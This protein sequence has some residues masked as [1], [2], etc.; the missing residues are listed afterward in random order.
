MAYVACVT[1]LYAHSAVRV[2]TVY[3]MG[4]V[5]SSYRTDH[6]KQLSLPQARGWCASW[7]LSWRLASCN[8]TETSY[9]PTHVVIVVLY[10]LSVILQDYEG[11][12]RPGLKPLGFGTKRGVIYCQ[13]TTQLT[14]SLTKCVAVFSA[15]VQFC[16]C[17][18][19]WTHLTYTLIIIILQICFKHSFFSSDQTNRHF[20][21]I[22]RFHIVSISYL[23]LHKRS[24][25]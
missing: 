12:R 4:I 9:T 5:I 20:R 19:A 16:S 8:W 10:Y 21:C 15:F 7:L 13:T 25:F 1:S 17:L 22:P 18:S 23:H 3:S 24:S 6:G 14:V 2:C 11:L